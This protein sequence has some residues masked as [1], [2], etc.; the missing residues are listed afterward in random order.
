MRTVFCTNYLLD[1]F[2]KYFSAEINLEK[3]EMH[4][5]VVD[6]HD[7]SDIRIIEHLRVLVTS[8]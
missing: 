4:N 8:R 2:F 1:Q 3:C 5:T 7:Y 6:L